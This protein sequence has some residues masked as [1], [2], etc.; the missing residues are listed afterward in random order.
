MEHEILS[1]M[2][3]ESE[4]LDMPEERNHDSSIKKILN[5]KYPP[6]ESPGLK[7]KKAAI[8]AALDIRLARMRR[9]PERCARNLMELGINSFPDKLSKEEQSDVFQ[10][11]MFYCKA[12]DL[13]KARELFVKSFF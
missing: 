3:G 4:D 2:I 1:E 13:Q 9:S 8:T 6:I 7:I 5:G 11:L 12:K 10:R